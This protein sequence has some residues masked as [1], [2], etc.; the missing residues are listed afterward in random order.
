VTAHCHDPR[1]ASLV[2]ALINAW[3]DLT[4]AIKVGMLTTVEALIEANRR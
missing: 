4:E 1:L 2:D 3:P